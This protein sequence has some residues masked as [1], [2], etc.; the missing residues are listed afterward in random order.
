MSDPIAGHDALVEELHALRQRVAQLESAKS[1]QPPELLGL[2]TAEA[3]SFLTQLLRH[4]PA[5]IYLTSLDGRYLFVNR[6]W[7]EVF[8]LPRRQVLGRFHRDILPQETARQLTDVNRRVIASEVPLTIEEQLEAADGTRFYHT[9]KFPVR[10]AD[11][12]LIA[13]GGISFDVTQRRRVEQA[14]RESEVRLRHF[15]DAT[16]EGIVLH[17]NGQI[18]DANQAAAMLFGYTSPEEL[19]GRDI[20]DFSPPSDHEKVRAQIRAGADHVYESFGLRKD[21]SI[22]PCE[23]CGKN[24]PY[25]GR[26]IRVTALRDVTA[27][28]AVEAQLHEYTDRLQALS[29]RLLEVQEEERQYLARELHDEIGQA[30]TGLQFTLELVERNGTD[31]LRAG[32]HEARGQVRELTGRVRDLSLRLRP[33]MLDDLGLLPALLW[34]LDRFTAQT[35]VQVVLEHHG[36]DRRFA[37][38]REVAAYRVVQ[39]ALTNVARHA[40]VQ[41]AAVRIQLD[42]GMLHLEIE[43]QGVGFDF[44]AVLSSGNCCGLSGMR[45]RVA[46]LGGRIAVV[47]APGAGTRLSAEWSVESDGRDRHGADTGAGR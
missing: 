29:R 39:E 45:Q 3:Q 6:A 10:D 23:I 36:L 11:G 13:V 18:V 32:V 5:P 2:G 41:E 20:Y 22:F 14:L 24:I 47:S 19:V 1:G 40:G 4:A 12:R 44:N 42:A 9:V 17:E 25:H 16:V 35:G 34:H 31:G 21:G 37:A 28:K 43:D 8:R 26:T 33:T 7:E 30:L 27:R 46:L 38:E 15:F